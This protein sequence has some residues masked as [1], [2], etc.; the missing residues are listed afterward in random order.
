MSETKA[1]Q[2]ERARFTIY[3]PGRFGQASK[4]RYTAALNK[5]AR[6]PLSWDSS[7]ARWF[8]SD[9]SA[10]AVMEKAGCD[11]FDRALPGYERLIWKA[12]N[13]ALED[14]CVIEELMRL[15][16]HTLDHL[17]LRRFNR[18]ARE[19]AASL[20]ELRRTDPEVAEYYEQCGHG[21][22]PRY[23]VPSA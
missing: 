17:D 23:E 4:S 2:A 6:L 14:A 15:E 1:E 3:P 7:D 20:S 22:H 13:C 11:V 5:A 16:Y 10:A 8:T 12:T 18:A 9:E 19:A 21:N